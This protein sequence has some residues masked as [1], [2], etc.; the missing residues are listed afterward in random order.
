MADLWEPVSGVFWGSAPL[1]PNMEWLANLGNSSFFTTVFGALAGA[2][3]GAWAAQRIAERGKLREELQRELRNINAGIT[4][5]FT[6]ANLVLSLKKQHVKELKKSYDS[7]CERHKAFVQ[8][9]ALGHVTG[10]FEIAPNLLSFQELS[11]PIATLQ[12]IVLGRLSTAGRAIA[13]VSAIA[14]AFGGLNFSI[15]KRNELIERI[16]E[17][18]LPEG[19]RA[20]HFYLGISYAAGKTN[21]EYGSFVGAM[22]SYTDDAIYFSIKLCE[23]LRVHGEMLAQR[24][25]KKFGGELPHV[26]RIDLSK[27]QEEGLLPKE[28]Q[29]ES[30]LSGFQSSEK[31]NT[32]LVILTRRILDHLSAY[33]MR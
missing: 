20:E 17:E 21:D 12:E 15:T 1:L 13:D 2:F 27:A 10:A 19:A 31:E 28:E 11:P 14:D 5:A 6:T 24:Y 32:L 23:D 7:D 30:W 33:F 9:F 4:L 22:A 8:D 18:K 25:K 3:A 29:Y 26:T 16:K